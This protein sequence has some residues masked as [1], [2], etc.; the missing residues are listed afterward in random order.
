MSRIKL[1]QISAFWKFQGN[2]KVQIRL[3]YFCHSVIISTSP[4]KSSPC[5]GYFSFSL[6]FVWNR[7]Q[8][9]FGLTVLTHFYILCCSEKRL[10]KAT[11][12]AFSF[13]SIKPPSSLISQSPTPSLTFCVKTHDRLYYMV[14]PSPEAM[15]IWMDVIVT[16]AEG[17]TQFMSWGTTGWAVWL[18]SESERA[19]RHLRANLSC[20]LPQPGLESNSLTA[21]NGWTWAD[22]FEQMRAHSWQG[23][24]SVI[25]RVVFI[26]HLAVWVEEKKHFE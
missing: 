6:L 20:S 1:W 13:C 17:Y 3:E 23:C 25:M 4:T 2:L 26:F 11:G 7:L 19:P 14:A 12:A 5:S 10:E 24:I 21:C 16:G 18:M 15:R 22:A 9:E 8:P